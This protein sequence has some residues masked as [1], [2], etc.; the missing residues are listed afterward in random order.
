MRKTKTIKGSFYLNSENLALCS[1]TALDNNWWIYYTKG[2]LGDFKLKY[3][4]TSP[5][6][7]TSDTTTI[8]VL[9]TGGTFAFSGLTQ[10]L[11]V[12]NEDGYNVISECTF[13]SGNVNIVTVSAGGLVTSA[14]FTGTTS[15][16][17]THTA[18]SATDTFEA[19]I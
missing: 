8:T 19:T 10:Q 17:A 4:T 9:P 15:V 14:T 3:T 12:T 7:V 11:T 13:G 6:L 5:T 18:S 16:T 2:A 1:L